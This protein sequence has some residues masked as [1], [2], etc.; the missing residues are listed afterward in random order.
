MPTWS[1]K[2]D[3]LREPR[4]ARRGLGRRRTGGGLVRVGIDIRDGRERGGLEAGFWECGNR[5]A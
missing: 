3:Q 1:G 5:P 2:L 4:I